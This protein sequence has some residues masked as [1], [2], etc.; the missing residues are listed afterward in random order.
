MPDGDA[1]PYANQLIMQHGA[2]HVSVILSCD[3]M[4]MTEEVR[5]QTGVV[6]LGNQ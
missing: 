5:R 2:I 3:A 4:C 1:A 6:G